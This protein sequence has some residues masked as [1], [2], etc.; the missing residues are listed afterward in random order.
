MSGCYFNVGLLVVIPF[1]ISVVAVVSTMGS[2]TIQLRII[3]IG[4]H[5]LPQIAN[6]PLNL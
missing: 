4:F 3:E 6:S 5:Q 1:R 2:V